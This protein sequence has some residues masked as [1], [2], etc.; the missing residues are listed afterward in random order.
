MREGN[1]S[2]LPSPPPAPAPPLSP[3]CPCPSPLPSP[4]LPY[5]TLIFIFYFNSL[6]GAKDTEIAVV[7]KGEEFSSQLVK[8]LLQK[9]TGQVCSE[10]IS[11]FLSGIPFKTVVVFYNFN[12]HTIRYHG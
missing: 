12:L 1:Y 5:P 8:M 6:V 2:P 7:V 9:H 4:L 10:A 3:S 11:S